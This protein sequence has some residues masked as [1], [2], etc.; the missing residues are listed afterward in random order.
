MPR[1]I[2]LVLTLIMITGVTRGLQVDTHTPDRQEIKENES[3]IWTFTITN[4]EPEPIDITIEFTDT[5]FPIDGHP[6]ECSLIPGE[7]IDG[8]Y[9]IGPCTNITEDVEVNSSYTIIDVGQISGNRGSSEKGALLTVMSI[10]EENTYFHS[11]ERDEPFPVEIVATSLLIAIFLFIKRHL[12]LSFF[13]P[14]YNKIYGDRLFTN[15]WRNEIFLAL[16]QNQDGLRMK[17]L[18]ECTGCNRDTARYHVRRLVK[19]GYVIKKPN[20]RYYHHL[21]NNNHIQSIEDTIRNLLEEN[22]EIRQVDIA[23]QLGISRQHAYYYMNKIKN[24]H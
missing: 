15:E 22:P 19:E 20:K 1:A 2:I 11:V 5:M 17:E 8:Y 16:E 10:E 7:D 6:I 14:L 18:S 12:F 21:N 4:N 3:A 9:L 24:G 23:N 13:P